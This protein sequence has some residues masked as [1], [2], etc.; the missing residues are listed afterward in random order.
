MGTGTGS[1]ALR[2]AKWRLMYHKLDN[3][4]YRYYD[5][6]VITQAHTPLTGTIDTRPIEDSLIILPNLGFN[7]H[8]QLNKML[9]SEWVLCKIQMAEQANIKI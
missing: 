5:P 9:K 7:N 8:A 2:S 3:T 1:K 6:N 4:G